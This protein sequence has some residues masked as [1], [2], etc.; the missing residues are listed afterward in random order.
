[1]ITTNE[2][3]RLRE[4]TGAGVLDCRE[5]LREAD[6]DFDLALAALRA[7]GAQAMEKRADRVAAHGYVATYSHHGLIG[8]LVELRC[9]TDFVANTAAFRDLAH[10]I[11]LQVAATDPRWVSRE[12]V[13][14][15]AVEQLA[16]DERTAA[17]AAGKLESI[18][19][20]IVTGKVERFYRDT[21]LLEQP[22]IR[23]EKSTI[24]ELIQDKLVALGERIYVARFARFAIEA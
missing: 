4:Q 1:M 7:R 18:V 21:C 19:E 5:A 6:G 13:P 14:A 8:V 9:E 11:A 20:R 22:S 16:A 3:K 17:V 2:I 12:D 24:N 10:E 15:E 23:D